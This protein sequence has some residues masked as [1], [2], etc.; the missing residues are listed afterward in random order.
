MKETEIKLNGCFYHTAALLKDLTGTVDL[1]KLK[2]LT[3]DYVANLGA[4]KAEI[5]RAMFRTC[6]LFNITIK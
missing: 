5:N 6:N 1:D 2:R 4:T 3:D